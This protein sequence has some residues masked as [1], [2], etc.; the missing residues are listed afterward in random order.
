MAA[1]A[2]G[3]ARGRELAARYATCGGKG[4][5]GR[6]VRRD[7]VRR[8]RVYQQEPGRRTPPKR[9]PLGLHGLGACAPLRAESLWRY[10]ELE[11]ERERLRPILRKED[12]ILIPPRAVEQPWEF[13]MGSPDDDTEALR[14][15]RPQHPVRIKRPFK[16]GRYEVTFEEYDRFAYATGRRPPSDA[17]FGAGLS[18]EK[19]RRLPV[20]NVSY[21]DAVAYAKWLSEQTGEEFR[22]PSEAEW[23]YA[24]RAGTRTRRFWGD[25]PSQACEHANVLDKRNEEKLRARYAISWEPHDCEDS[26]ADIAPVG[27]FKPNRWGLYDMLGNVYEW[28]QD[29]WHKNYE[30]A[31]KDGSR[32][33]EAENDGNC[34]LRVFRGGSWYDDPRG[35]RSAYRYRLGPD[36]RNFNLG[37]RLAQDLD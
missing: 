1:P 4:L 16:M 7:G 5:V 32:A 36:F 35:V 31:P 19:R 3:V 37:F 20:I 11:A 25:A 8:A 26:Y 2:P 10:R 14:T 17:G 21:E 28:L 23:E 12:W 27:Q 24:A 9:G 18:D 22:L 29:C 30:G 34:A 15:Q 13:Q 6:A 33:W